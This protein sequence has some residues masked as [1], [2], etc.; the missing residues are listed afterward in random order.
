MGL[1]WRVLR[2][3]FDSN[4]DYPLWRL[5]NMQRWKFNLYLFSLSFLSFFLNEPHYLILRYFRADKFSRVFIFQI[6][7]FL[8]PDIW[9]Y[10]RKT[11]VGFAKI[12]LGFIFVRKSEEI[13]KLFVI[14]SFFKSP[15]RRILIYKKKHSANFLTL[16]VPSS[17]HMFMHQLLL[18]TDKLRQDIWKY[19]RTTGAKWH[20]ICTK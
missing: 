10:K 16:Q 1:A 18:A 3:Y 14:C 2:L 15:N 5:E 17:Y 11:G 19:P 7:S 9:Q 20:C 12:H 4:S 8:K 13:Q 6:L